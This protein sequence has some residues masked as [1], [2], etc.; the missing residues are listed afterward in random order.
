MMEALFWVTLGIILTLTFEK[1]LPFNLGPEQDQID[2][3]DNDSGFDGKNPDGT[4]R[5]KD[6]VL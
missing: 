5:I 6:E 2:K 3:K 4:T 1:Y